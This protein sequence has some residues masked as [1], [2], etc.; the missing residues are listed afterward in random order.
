MSRCLLTCCPKVWGSKS[1]ALGFCPVRLTGTRCKRATRLCPCGYRGT[2]T[3]ECRCDDAAVAKYVSKISGPLLDRIDLQ[4]E[5]SR[6]AFD[7]MVRHEPA[8]RS[9]AIRERVIAARELQ[10][11]RYVGTATTCNAEVP[12]NAVHTYCLL[13]DKALQL[14]SHASAK[15]QFSARAL[16]RIARAARTIADLAGSETIAAPHVA[17]ALQYRS[18]ERLGTR[19]A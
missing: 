1:A 19:A 11:Q 2:R 7:D 14:L 4:I 6:V 10:R 17:E 12:G 3:A 18:L 13:D 16:D 8:E 15:R 5:V 9:S